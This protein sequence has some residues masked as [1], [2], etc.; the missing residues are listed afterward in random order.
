MSNVTMPVVRFRAPLCDPTRHSKLTPRTNS[1]IR[2]EPTGLIT[3]GR[4]GCICG[5]ASTSGVAARAAA[6][7]SGMNAGLPCPAGAGLDDGHLEA[8][9]VGFLAGPGEAGPPARRA[10]PADAAHPRGRVMR[11]GDGLAELLDGFHPG[12]DDAVGADVEGAF[13][14]TR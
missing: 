8:S 9:L 7:L 5:G 3:S 6:S 14:Q 12:D 10:S 4:S 11:E 2:P 13:D 1:E